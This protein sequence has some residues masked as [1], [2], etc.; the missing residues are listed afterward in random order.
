MSTATPFL[1]PVKP[2][3]L[4]EVVSNVMTTSVD[5]SSHS[6]C[7]TL[8]SAIWFVAFSLLI[9]CYQW[10]PLLILYQN[11]C[12]SVLLCNIT[13]FSKEAVADPTWVQS[14]INKIWHILIF[15][16][17]QHGV[18]GYSQQYV[19]CVDMCVMYSNNKQNRKGVKCVG[20]PP[21]ISS[22]LMQSSLLK[23]TGT[24]KHT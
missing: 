5:D 3:K 20:D 17:G 6:Y 22:H 1:H 8:G 7:L 10:R 13:M 21:P 15:C 19:E 2:R 16:N 9:N 18:H 23:C 11:I 4:E 14:I 12:R 24:T